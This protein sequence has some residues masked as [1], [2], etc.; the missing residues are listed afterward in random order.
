MI[1]FMK[2]RLLLFIPLALAML[3]SAAITRAQTSGTPGAPPAAQAAQARTTT[4]YTLSNGMQLWVRP[5]RRAPTAVHMLWVRVG[6]M[7]EV[8]GT[9]GVAH[10]LEHMLFQGTARLGPGL[11]ETS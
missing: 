6:S 10:V 11:F 7:D 5:D 2:P 4:T 3:A 1:H 8:D 9:S